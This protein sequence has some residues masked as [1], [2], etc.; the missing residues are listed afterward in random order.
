[1]P[2]PSPPW[3][4]RANAWVSTFALTDAVRA[5]RPAGVY[6][7]AFVDY[8]DGG[9]LQYHELV[10][11]GLLRDGAVPRIRITDIWVDSSESLAGGRALW[12]I[13]KQPADLPLREGRA[14][15]V[16]RTSFRAVGLDKLDHRG[17]KLDHPAERPEVARGVFTSVPG[18]ALVRMPLR[19][20]TSQQRE[21][22][23]TVVTSLSGSARVVPCL[24]RWT[25][26]ADGP[27]GF[28]SGRRP[29]LSVHLL[30][31]RLRFG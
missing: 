29:L 4:L 26:A 15:V 28:L 27:L 5:D 3:S 18:A 2:F 23:T 9:V 22:G 31:V 8:R 13:P 6:A 10:V 17:D 30:D 25:M 21:D 19:G 14:G 11:A 20:S 12:A 7:A 24:G 1:V 16:A